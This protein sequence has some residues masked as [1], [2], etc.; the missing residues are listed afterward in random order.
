[1]SALETVAEWG[2]LQ[3]TST[4]SK[5]SAEGNEDGNIHSE[6]QSPVEDTEEKTN[7]GGE[8]KQAQGILV[9]ASRIVLSVSTVLVNLLRYETK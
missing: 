6:S 3:D 9:L 4:G 5:P 2:G 7:D 1:M 8:K